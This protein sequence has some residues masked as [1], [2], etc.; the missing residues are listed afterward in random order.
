MNQI[1]EFSKDQKYIFTMG[2]FALCDSNSL[3][4]YKIHCTVDFINCD[5]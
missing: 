2:F 5:S 1:D 3:H 4:F